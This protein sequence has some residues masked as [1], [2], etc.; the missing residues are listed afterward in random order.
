M[1]AYALAVA[2]AA[3]CLFPGDAAAQLRSGSTYYGTRTTTEPQ[4]GYEGFI[5]NGRRQIYCSYWRVPNRTCDKRGCRVTSWTLH[6][7]CG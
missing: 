2:I 7:N 5:T 6:Q 4:R 3:A 1:K